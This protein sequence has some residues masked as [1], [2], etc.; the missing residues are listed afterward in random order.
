MKNRIKNFEKQVVAKK[1]KLKYFLTRLANN[2]PISTKEITTMTSLLNKE[3]WK[4]VDCMKCAKCCKTMTPTYSV[5]EIKKIALHFKMTEVEF[6]KKWLYKDRSKDWKNKST[7][8]Q[9]LD[10]NKLC[11]IYTIRPKDCKQ[12][13]YHYKKD[14]LEYI[15][16]FRQ[17]LEYCPATFLLVE[18]LKEKIHS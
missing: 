9:F 10:K 18:K 8:C 17:N 7:P 6:K 15:E 5:Q 2:P 1:R 3:V 16:T 14:T 11:S 13:P 4:E 12:F